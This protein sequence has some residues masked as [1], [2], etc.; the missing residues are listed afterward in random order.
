MLIWVFRA[1]REQF[2]HWNSEMGRGAVVVAGL[3][4]VYI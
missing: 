3:C 2:E 1:K 4:E